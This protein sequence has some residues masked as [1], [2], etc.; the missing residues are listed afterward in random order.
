[1]L[2]CGGWR[3]DHWVLDGMASPEG[4]ESYPVS[5]CSKVT[6]F[7]IKMINHNRKLL[8]VLQPPGLLPLARP[9]QRE[10]PRRL[11]GHPL[12]R[13]RRP[14]QTGVQGQCSDQC[15]LIEN[16]KTPFRFIL[17]RCTVV[18]YVNRRHSFQLFVVVL[19]TSSV[20]YQLV[21]PSLAHA[22]PS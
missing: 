10:L 9:H 12:P 17:T 8:Y 3:R 20:S 13:R 22:M 5:C 21:S 18:H 1:M 6:N 7:T 4:R 15:D 2:A 16:V 11:Q 19:Y 14:G